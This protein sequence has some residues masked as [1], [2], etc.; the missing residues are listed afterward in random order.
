MLVHPKPDNSSSQHGQTCPGQESAA[1]EKC[2]VHGTWRAKRP[3]ENSSLVVAVCFGVQQQCHCVSVLWC[4]CV[5]NMCSAALG[6]GVRTRG[7]LT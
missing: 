1:G 2:N 3:E 5:E 4:C 7:T 6:V